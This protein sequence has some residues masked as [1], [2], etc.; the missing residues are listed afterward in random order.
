MIHEATRSVARSARAVAA[1]LLLLTLLAGAAE[2]QTPDRRVRFARG[3]TRA[4]VS[5]R[6]TAARPEAVF[7]FRARRGQHAR[8]RLVRAAGPVRTYF[9]LPGGEEE[10]QPGAGIIYE[11]ELP[12]TGDYRVRVHQSPMGNPWRGPFLLEITIR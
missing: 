4:R 1:L 12:A 10:G 6:L 5:G 8:V 2:A 7:V 9:V 3:A 11:D